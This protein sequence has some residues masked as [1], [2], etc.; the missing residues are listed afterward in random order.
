MYRKTISRLKDRLQ[1][2]EDNS[3]MRMI[4]RKMLKSYKMRL[5]ENLGIFT[6]TPP[7]SDDEDA[8]EPIIKDFDNTPSTPHFFIAKENEQPVTSSK[9]VELHGKLLAL[10]TFT[11]EPYEK[12]PPIEG[13][14]PKV[15]DTITSVETTKTSKIIKAA[16]VTSKEDK[17]SY[18]TTRKNLKNLKNPKDED[19]AEPRRKDEAQQRKK[20]MP[21]PAALV[22]TQTPY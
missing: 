10:S 9:L 1:R 4:L 6:S 2:K 8:D 17:A 12:K 21:K 11:E 15:D 7:S 14:L 19:H 20:N 16:Q 13:K 3:T 22:S 18:I 5:D